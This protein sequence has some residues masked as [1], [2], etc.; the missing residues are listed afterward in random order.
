MEKIF[1]PEGK[2]AILLLAGGQF[3]LG[4][5]IGV[6]GTTIGEIC[7]TTGMTG[8]QET[9][10]D[11]SFYGQI[12]TFTFPHI[13]VVGCNSYDQESDKVYASGLIIRNDLTSPSNYRSEM[14]TNAWLKEKKI[15]GIAEIDTRAL[16]RHIRENGASNVLIHYSEEREV[17]IAELAGILA[18]AP[19]MDGLELCAK[20]STKEAYSWQ[21]GRFAEETPQKKYK[22]VAIDYGIKRNILRSLVSVGCEVV[23]VSCQATADEI[24]AHKPDGIFLS[25]GP[26][27]PAS[28]SIYAKEIIGKLIEINIPIFCIC[29]G[30]QLLALALG[31]KTEKLL[32]GHRGTNHPVKNLLNNKIEITSQNHGFAVRGDHIPD[33]MEITHISLFDH[34]IEGFRVK[35]KPIFSVQYHPESSPGPHDSRYLFEQFIQLMDMHYAKA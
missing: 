35:D 8:Y 32:Q 11:P 19:N 18:Q 7:F 26:G 34:T 31:A 30:H 14:S 25:N 16:T 12:I 29:M 21:E 4:K 22:V 13:G 15:T 27:D 24:L 10:T 20:V 33:N 9:L 1:L 2:D 5:G 6:K 3:F 23:V 17:D 28:T